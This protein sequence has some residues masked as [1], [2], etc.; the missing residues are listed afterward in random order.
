MTKKAKSAATPA[1]DHLIGIAEMRFTDLVTEETLALIRRDIRAS[2]KNIGN[3]TGH[4]F[5]FCP[6][7]G[8]SVEEAVRRLGDYYGACTDAS[9]YAQKEQ[10]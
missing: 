5:R 8:E 6:F 1:C 9:I 10:G 2:G 7:C 3:W 4:Q